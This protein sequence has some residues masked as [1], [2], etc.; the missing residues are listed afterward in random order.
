MKNR[1]E[2]IFSL[3][4]L[5]AAA[6]TPAVVLFRS[7]AKCLSDSNNHELRIMMMVTATSSLL[8]GT[9]RSISLARIDAVLEQS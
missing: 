1:D 8:F 6:A 5:A 7:L 4:P 3:P 2:Q 9:Q